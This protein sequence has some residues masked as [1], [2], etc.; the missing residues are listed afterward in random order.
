MPSEATEDMSERMIRS[1]RSAGLRYVN[2]DEPGITRIRAGRGF[3]YLLP[4][5]DQLKSYRHLKRIARLAIPPAYREVWICL[6]DDGHIQAIGRDAKGRKQ[7]RYHAAWR[8]ARDKK[9]FDRM[10]DFAAVLPQLRER[11]AR[12]LA[13]DGLDKAK[14]VA[15]ASGRI[16]TGMATA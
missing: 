1:A 8:E 13:R 11:V 10:F 2:D 14:V 9:K 16:Q 3:R 15:A 6:D 7:Y 12:D 4:S 5:G